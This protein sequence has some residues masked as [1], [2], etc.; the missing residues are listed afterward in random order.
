MSKR[1]IAYVKASGCG[2]IF[3]LVDQA[4]APREK[5]P[6]LTVQMC[7]AQG[8]DGVEWTA[9][10]PGPDAD[11]E[12]ILINADGS[13]AEISGNGTR[14]VAAHCAA[15]RGIGTVRVRTG[16]GVKECKLITRQENVFEFEMNLGIP[17]VDG[18]IELQLPTGKIKGTK[19]S[20]GN[21]QFVVFV[22]DFDL[23]WRKQ[24]AEIQAQKIFIH[25][26]NVDFVRRVS[27]TEI[28]ARFFE[29]GVGETQSSGTGSCASAVAAIASGLAES[30][31]KVN[32]PGGPQTVVWEKSVWLRGPAKLEEPGIIA[33]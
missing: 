8:A 2:N 6:E 23:D 3:L 4:A 25:G 10:D 30:P 1:E 14:C 29:R 20:M 12:A 32:A 26:T 19:L 28:E 21:P 5:W 33:L 24:G 31:V 15:T 22:S 7:A 11:M 17:Q 16:A 9:A 18:E 27:A 13:E